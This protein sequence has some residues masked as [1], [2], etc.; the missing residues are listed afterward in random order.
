MIVQ[1]HLR[2]ITDEEK[3]QLKDKILNET[4]TKYVTT[5]YE[6]IVTGMAKSKIQTISELK[7]TN[8]ANVPGIIAF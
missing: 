7:N 5:W 6:P 2:D 3:S 8:I 1:N 4:R